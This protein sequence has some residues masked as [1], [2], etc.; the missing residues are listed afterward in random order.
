MGEVNIEIEAPE[1]IIRRAKEKIQHGVELSDAEI[2]VLLEHD[3][4]SPDDL[5]E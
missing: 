2:R 1:Q 3:A 4:V 5:A